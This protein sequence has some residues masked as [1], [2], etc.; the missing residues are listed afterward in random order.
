MKCMAEI[1]TESEPSLNA[2][3]EFFSIWLENAKETW[4]HLW[5]Y[6]KW[7]TDD[8]LKKPA[9]KCSGTERTNYCVLNC[10]DF[11]H[12]VY[13]ILVSISKPPHTSF[14]ST[15]IASGLITPLLHSPNVMTTVKVNHHF[16]RSDF[17]SVRSNYP[18]RVYW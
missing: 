6:W 18:S 11:S 5:P 7:N 16:Y 17:L 1:C 3:S 12:K 8:F 9:V 15:I 10:V 14:Q 2:F 4:F 13:S